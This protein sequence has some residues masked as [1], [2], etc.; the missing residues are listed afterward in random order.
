MSRI[1]QA[2]PISPAKEVRLARS[3]AGHCLRLSVANN[4]PQR[5][6]EA[7]RRLGRGGKAAGARR[8]PRP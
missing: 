6:E 2:K 8:R 1:L 7:I 4:P 3:M 5:I